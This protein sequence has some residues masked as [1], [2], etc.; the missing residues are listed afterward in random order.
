MQIEFGEDFAETTPMSP[1]F[2][3]GAAAHAAGVP[4]STPPP[5]YPTEERID[6]LAGWEEAEY[7]SEA[8]NE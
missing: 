8:W 2:L 7:A 1:A 5:G 4:F 6:W 3:E